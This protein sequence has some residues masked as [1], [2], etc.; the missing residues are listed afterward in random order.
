MILDNRDDRSQ[1]IVSNDFPLVMDERKKKNKTVWEDLVR[2]IKKT[3]ARNVLGNGF[4]FVKKEFR[5]I[6]RFLVLIKSKR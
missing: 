4:F 5:T 3:D 6:R 2:Y 1:T